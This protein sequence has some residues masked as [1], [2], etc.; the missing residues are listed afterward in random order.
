VTLP[1]TDGSAAGVLAVDAGFYEFVPEEAMDAATPPVLLAHELELGRRYDI[2]LTGDNGLYRYDLNDVVEVQ[3]FHRA[4]PLLAFV[5]KGRD[6]TS[7]TGEKL[8]LDHVQ[9]A[10]RAAESLTGVA[11]WQFRLIPDVDACRY[12]LLIEPR[13][14]G[15]IGA[16]AFT[17]AVDEGL[18]RIN[19]EYAAKR[20]SRRLGPP[21]L[22][23]M[24]EGWAERQCQ[25]EFARGGREVQHKWAAIRTEWD[26]ASH[27][28][29]VWMWEGKAE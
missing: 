27:A 16:E 25:A 22:C 19:V 18:A 10:V 28:E 11:V 29:V 5:R 8:H 26:L 9:A 23:V 17:C 3:G 4:P 13:A 15:P 12:D 1:L 14:A 21:R 2:I 24:R 7:I 6:M 20:R